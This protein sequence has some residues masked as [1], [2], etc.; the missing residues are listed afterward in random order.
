MIET[1]LIDRVWYIQLL[2]LAH[3][4]CYIFSFSFFKWGKMNQVSNPSC[5]TTLQPLHPPCPSIH[6]ICVSTC[7]NLWVLPGNW[8]ALI[9][10]YN[11]PQISLSII[12]YVRRA[13]R[14]CFAHQQNWEQW[15]QPRTTVSFFLER[16][17]IQTLAQSLF[18]LFQSTFFFP[19]VWMKSRETLFLKIH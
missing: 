15:Q 8:H 13:R 17:D 19:D 2:E 14:S 18:F 6:P 7:T 11:P 5:I 9:H 12:S 3:N 1:S 4:Y 10:L 16:S